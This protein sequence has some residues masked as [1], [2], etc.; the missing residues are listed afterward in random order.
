MPV[1]GSW[2]IILFRSFVLRVVLIKVENPASFFA[3]VY[4]LVTF[5]PPKFLEGGHS[6]V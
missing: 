1:R 3:I 2:G 5:C 6:E 4:L